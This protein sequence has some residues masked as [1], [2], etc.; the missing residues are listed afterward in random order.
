MILHQTNLATIRGTAVNRTAEW[1]LRKQNLTPTRNRDPI[2]IAT[3][4]EIWRMIVRRL[5][6]H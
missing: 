5:Y 2:R 6:A 1:Q 4:R 3:W